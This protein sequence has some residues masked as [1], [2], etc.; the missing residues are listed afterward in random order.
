MQA[1]QKSRPQILD[2]DEFR[3]YLVAQMQYIM[4]VTGIDIASPGK[5]GGYQMVSDFANCVSCVNKKPHLVRLAQNSSGD[6]YEYQEKE[7]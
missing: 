1:G 7:Y 4:A 2:R 6:R 5:E 3:I